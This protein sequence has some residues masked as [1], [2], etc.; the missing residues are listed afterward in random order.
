MTS[1]DSIYGLVS[2]TANT[3]PTAAPGAP[4]PQDPQIAELTR[5]VDTL[6]K[7]LEAANKKLDIFEKA[8]GNKAPSSPSSTAPQRDPVDAANRQSHKSLLQFSRGHDIAIDPETRK[9]NPKVNYQEELQ[10]YRN[11][12]KMVRDQK[13]S[14]MAEEYKTKY[15]NRTLDPS[16]DFLHSPM[17][18][19]AAKEAGFYTEWETEMDG[20]QSQLL[21]KRS[22]DR[23]ELRQRQIPRLDPYHSYDPILGKTSNGLTYGHLHDKANALANQWGEER[24]AQSIARA[25]AHRATLDQ[26]NQR[27]NDIQAKIKRAEEKPYATGFT[28]EFIKTASNKNFQNASKEL[29]AAR[30]E[31]Y[32]FQKEYHQKYKTYY[33]PPKNLLAANSP[34]YPR[35]STQGQNPN[36]Q[37]AF[38]GVANPSGFPLQ[39]TQT[40]NSTPGDIRTS[41][42]VQKPVSVSTPQTKN[43][44]LTVTKK[45]NGADISSSPAPAPILKHPATSASPLQDDVKPLPNPGKDSLIQ[46]YNN[47]IQAIKRHKYA[48]VENGIVVN[49][50]EGDRVSV[51]YRRLHPDGKVE[52][53]ILQINDR[54][55]GFKSQFTTYWIEN[56]KLNR[57]TFRTNLNG[58]TAQMDDTVTADISAPSH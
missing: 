12:Q 32:Q 34:L 42:P 1:L 36:T 2:R 14:D 25:S 6:T 44:G 41:T 46:D 4:V 9:Y 54:Q 23:A 28:R 57:G 48:R 53:G 39:N 37:V 52:T 40:P 15:K 58:H 21:A 38:S 47:L 55:L 10:S 27:Y 33:I 5:K 13:I 11:Y 43:P 3:I 17:G 35:L 45:P 22:A 8:L 18:R 51:G 49:Q 56:G 26:V 31:Y 20:R 29:G 30:E 19:D 24:N 7:Q 50:L 16:K